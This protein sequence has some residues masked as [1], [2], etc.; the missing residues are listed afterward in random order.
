MDIANFIGCITGTIGCITGVTSLVVSLK[1]ASFH[2][3]KL[4][5]EQAQEAY[6]YYFDSQKCDNIYNWND[7]KFPALVSLQITNSSN[8][9]ISITKVILKKDNNEVFQGNDFKHDRIGVMPGS[10]DPISDTYIGQAYFL[11]PYTIANIPLA[12][13][14]FKSTQVAFAFPFAHKIIKKYGETL[15]ATLELHTSRNQVIKTPVNIVEY[16]AHFT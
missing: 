4:I 9:P 5:I 15:S 2:K 3:G 12:L 7:T 11:E 1:Q 13:E 16:F 14:P 8:Y 10:R 6:S